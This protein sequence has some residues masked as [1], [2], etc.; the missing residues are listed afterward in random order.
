MEARRDAIESERPDAHSE[1]QSEHNN[2][3]AEPVGH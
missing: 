2:Y 1:T 3:D